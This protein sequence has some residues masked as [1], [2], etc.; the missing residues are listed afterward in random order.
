MQIE[1]DQ[2][3]AQNVK[4][5]LTAILSADVEGYSRLMGEDELTTIRTLTEYRETMSTLI[6]QHHGRVVDASGDNLLAEFASVVD[7]VQ[8]AVEVQRELAE[9]NEKLS[10]YRKMQFRIGVNLGDVVEEE[11][12]IYGDGVNI[13]ARLEGICDAGGVCI[14]G[15]AY[16]HVENKLKLEIQDL[17]EHNVKNITK[18]V[19]VYKVV[20]ASDSDKSVIAEALELPDK[21]SIAVLPFIN[22]SEDPQQEYFSDGI[23]EEIITGLSKILNLFVIASNSSFSYKGKHVKIQQVGRELGVQYVLE[24]SVRKVF[25]RVRITAQLINATTGHH[26]W[27]ERFNGDL[28]D[29]FALQDEITMKIL[30]AMQLKLTEGEQARLYGRS[31]NNLEAYL[32]H[33]QGHQYAR[34]FNKESTDLARQL[35]EEAIDLDPQHAMAYIYLAILHAVDVWLGSSQSPKDSL[36]KATELVHTSMS[37]DESLPESHGVLGL[38]YLMQKQHAKAIAEIELAV[39]GNPNSAD[40][41]ARLGLALYFSGE[42]KEAIAALNKA[43]RLN[44]IPPSWYLSTLGWVY[45]TTELHEEAIASF[46]KALQLSPDNL[47]AWQGLAATYSLAGYGAEARSAA[48]NV[49][50]IE[51]KFSL[52]YL[53]DVLPFKNKRDTKLVIDALCKAGLK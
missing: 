15:A 27:A 7:A 46:R 12:R 48:E 33:L 42:P 25:D 6:Q 13:A 43:I 30:I 45:G 28:E 37:I 16:E 23:T 31:T 10:E 29:I 49:L 22:M 53:A 32:K 9:H 17:G 52:E 40:D 4:R 21:P 38:I 2:I 47:Q 34:L 44:P 35:F 14:S 20:M 19:R 41:S 36:K 1:M 8:C 50:R 11:N 5:K 26:L 3:N 39:I 24:G 18:P 51:P